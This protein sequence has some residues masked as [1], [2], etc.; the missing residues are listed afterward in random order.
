MARRRPV[1]AH[2]GQQVDECDAQH[3]LCVCV[4]V[5]VRACARTRMD[6]VCLV[7][8]FAGPNQQALFVAAAAASCSRRTHMHLDMHMHTHTHKP[9][10]RMPFA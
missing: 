3:A 4:C 8:A 6:G 2:A 1:G 5:C 7:C 10:Q 9:P